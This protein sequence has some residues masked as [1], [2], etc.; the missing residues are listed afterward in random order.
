MTCAFSSSW[1]SFAPELSAI[2]VITEFM[3]PPIKSARPVRYI[4][5]ISMIT[6]P[7]DPYVALYELKKL[8]YN[9]KPPVSNTHSMI[10]KTEPG[11]THT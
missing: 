2:S 7:S 11:L 8:K 1:A 9:R 3:A 5:S 4:Q 6:A 10:S